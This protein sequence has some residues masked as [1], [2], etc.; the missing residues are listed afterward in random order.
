M[1]KV[2]DEINQIDALSRTKTFFPV[3]LGTVSM[4]DDIQY[5]DGTPFSV[6]PGGLLIDVT[7]ATSGP[8]GIDSSGVIDQDM[9]KLR[10]HSDSANEHEVWQ[11]LIGYD[12]IST[13]R[14]FQMALAQKGAT[15]NSYSTSSSLNSLNSVYGS[16]FISGL[17]T[18][19]NNTS[20]N[21]DS[22]TYT[23][24][25]EQVRIPSGN[26]FTVYM[27]QTTGNKVCNIAPNVPLFTVDC[28]EMAIYNGI[29]SANGGYV[30]N[31]SA[32]KESG[33]K[34]RS[35]PLRA[36]STTARYFRISTSSAW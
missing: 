33:S 26:L 18:N 25:N 15:L 4:L 7:L 28:N 5:V 23:L 1:A 20:N 29:F 34:T 36:R 14:G 22:L 11:E 8:Y 9:F 17:Q 16:D 21:G 32:L 6:T 24:P 3:F 35:R 12:A 13:V 30:D 2:N 19:I 31:N 10:C 27:G